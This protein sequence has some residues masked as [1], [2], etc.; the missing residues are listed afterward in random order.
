MYVVALRSNNYYYCYLLRQLSFED[1]GD[2]VNIQLRGNPI[3][4]CL[5]GHCSSNGFRLQY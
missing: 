4:S 5:A 1:H 3:Q 2:H